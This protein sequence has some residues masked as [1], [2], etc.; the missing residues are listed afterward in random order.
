MFHSA[1]AQIGSGWTPT[2]ESYVPQTSA[3]CTIA[4]VSG[5]WLFT[6]PGP[7]PFRDV[8]R[9]PNLPTNVKTQ[10]QGDVDYVSMGGNR[11]CC[12]QLFAPAPSAPWQILAFDK[13][14]AANAGA[15][16]DAASQPP[17][18]PGLYPY[19]IGLAARVNVIFDPVGQTVDV[20]INGMH[21]KQDSGQAGPNDFEIG[22][23]TLADGTGPATISW[24]N[25]QFW[26]AGVLPPFTITASA[27]GNGT[28]TPSGTI[29]VSPGG[30]QTF[31]MTPNPGFVVLNV[32]VD[33]A[34]VGAVTSY[35]FMGTTNGGSHTIS[36][37]FTP[38][39]GA[40]WPVPPPVFGP[41]GGVYATP[42][43]VTI[44]DG[45]SIVPSAISLTIRYTTDGSEPGPDNGMIYT[46]PIRIAATTHLQAIAIET[47]SLPPPLPIFAV[48]LSTVTSATY[49]ITPV[50]APTFSEAGGTYSE[51]VHVR[52]ADTT[53]GATIRYTTD[54]STP[55]ETHGTLVS[56][57]TLRIESTATLQAMAYLN[58]ADSSVTSASYTIT[59]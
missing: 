3:G 51:E 46:G 15:F 52:I 56:D 36:V 44:S 40:V 58:G 32:T 47:V 45:I 29:L 49:T 31:T 2:A 55:T 48:Y 34:S 18:Q 5:G 37:T 20:Y 50:A 7:G 53:E 1:Q 22:A 33:G 59:P 12:E 10:L 27:I 8:L 57:H 21:V 25:V 13:S 43:M 4:P 28:I 41:G 11:V 19:A 6:L 35:T 26:T 24:T 17:P 16:Y 9:F 39:G 38:S 30:S 42:Q 54:G 14:L 23:F